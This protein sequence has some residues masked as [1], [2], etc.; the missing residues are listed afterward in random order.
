[1]DPH[2]Y[3]LAHVLEHGV[4]AF[5]H[6]DLK[7]PKSIWMLLRRPGRLEAMYLEGRRVQW[8]RPF[9]LFVLV[10]V[11][12]YAA[13]AA[14]HLNTFQTSLRIHTSATPYAAWASARA[15]AHAASLGVSMD[16]YAA[17]FDAVAHTLSKTLIIALVPMLALLLAALFWKRRRYIL[18]HF[19]VALFWVT[20]ALIL[21]VLPFPLVLLIM[22]ATGAPG[23]S[24]WTLLTFAVFSVVSW[25]VF[26]RVYGGRAWTNGLR[27]VGMCF[28]FYMLLLFAYRPLLF[29]IASW[30]I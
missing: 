6:L 25:L 13:A 17:R 10:N 2:D 1:M 11:F 22:N 29:V 5:T 21:L 3:A 26:Q 15:T 20:R 16:A 23:D 30:L 4:D 27:A 7:V 18:E 19:Y 24:A 9:Q 12:Y 8:A 14:M 28:G